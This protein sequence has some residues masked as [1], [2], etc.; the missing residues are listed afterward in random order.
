MKADNDMELAVC[1]KKIVDCI[2]RKVTTDGA[3]KEVSIKI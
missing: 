3:K 1:Q 2:A